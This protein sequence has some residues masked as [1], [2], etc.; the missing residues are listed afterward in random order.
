MTKSTELS[1][2]QRLVQRALLTY[3]R[4]RN[5][6]TLGVR[7]VLVRDGQVLLVRHSYVP[8]WYFPGGAVDGGEAVGEAL[9]REMQEE[10]G[11]V[12]SGP[13]KLF[14]IYRNVAADRRDH[15]AL[16]VCPAWEQPAPPR[17]PNLEIV[18]W[19]MV[20]VTALPEDATAATRARLDEVLNG[21]APAEDW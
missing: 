11:V 5:G 7:G 21:A 4:L 9:R 17:V 8:G 18:A 13:P 20:P 12:L 19:A 1:A 3:G 16:F 6:V 15:V 2:P 10:V 14:G